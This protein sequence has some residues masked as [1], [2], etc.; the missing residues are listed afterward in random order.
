MYCGAVMLVLFLP[1]MLL[2]ARSTLAENGDEGE[3][4]SQGV[5]ISED[6]W[7]VIIDEKKSPN[8]FGF[9]QRN[10]DASNLA[11]N[12]QVLLIGGIVLFALSVLGIIFFSCYLYRV[13]KVPSTKRGLSKRKGERYK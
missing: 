11:D 2:N 6:D 5:Q 1:F 3:F 7:S 9:I 4:A 8:E 13:C 10:L 12:G